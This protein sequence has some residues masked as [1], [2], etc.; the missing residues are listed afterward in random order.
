MGG[1][2][3]RSGA[4]SVWGW[5]ADRLRLRAADGEALAGRALRNELSSVVAR[6]ESDSMG[7]ERGAVRVDKSIE[8][9]G[10]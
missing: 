3:A 4:V 1:E 10:K 5:R 2:R 7:G 6:A 8:R 9:R